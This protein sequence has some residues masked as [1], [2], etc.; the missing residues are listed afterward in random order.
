MSRRAYFED[1]NIID[2]NQHQPLD[3][4][5]PLSCILVKKAM[6]V[7]LIDLFVARQCQFPFE[8][9]EKRG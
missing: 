5:V 9:C 1:R 8:Q 6:R 3:H 2:K 4:V 7:E